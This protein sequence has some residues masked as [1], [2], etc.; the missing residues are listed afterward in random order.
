MSRPQGNRFRH[1]FVQPEEDAAISE[2]DIGFGQ[3]RHE[4]LAVERRLQRPRRM[5]A[6]EIASL[7]IDR[8]GS[9]SFKLGN[10]LLK[11]LLLRV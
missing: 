5:K 10:P 8:Q 1:P 2:N 4:A 9:R 7:F 3:N 11:P 6:G